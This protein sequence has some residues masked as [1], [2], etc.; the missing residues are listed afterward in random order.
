MIPP[1]ESPKICTLPFPSMHRL[2]GVLSLL[3]LAGRL[4]ISAL[5]VGC[6]SAL[7]R[8]QPVVPDWAEDA[9]WYQIFPERFANGDTANDPSGV[10]PWGGKPEAH[11]YFGGD[12]QGACATGA[13]RRIDG[14]REDLYELIRLWPLRIRRR[15]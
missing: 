9:I 13:K 8:A 6:L 11:N 2:H 12:L 10:Q 1:A 5:V 3:R 14:A 4:S 7:V 15:R